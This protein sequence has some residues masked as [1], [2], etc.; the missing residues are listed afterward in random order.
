MDAVFDGCVE[1][2]EWLAP[3]VGLTYKEINVWLFVILMPGLLLVLAAYCLYLRRRVR[4]LETRRIKT[5]R[6]W[7]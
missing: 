6:D 4:R 7:P 3:L 5:A 1:F 2:L